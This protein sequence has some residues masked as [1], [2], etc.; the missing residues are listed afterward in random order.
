MRFPSKTSI[1]TIIRKCYGKDT[2]KQLRKFEKL[3]NTVRKNQGDMDEN[4]LTSKFL[5]F[6]LTNSN[7]RSLNSRKQYQSL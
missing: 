3:D 7:H 6:K 1:A 5:N 4:G 2:V